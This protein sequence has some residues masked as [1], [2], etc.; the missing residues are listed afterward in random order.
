M[1]YIYSIV[2]GLC[3]LAI[4]VM[5]QRFYIDLTPVEPEE[6]TLGRATGTY[7]RNLLPEVTSAYD[8]GTS[9]LKWNRLFNNYTSSTITET[10]IIDLPLAAAPAYQPGRLFYE[11]YGAL[12]GLSFYSSEADSI[13][14]IGK[15]NWKDVRNCNSGSVIA[16]GTAVYL[17]GV[18]VGQIPCVLPANATVLNNADL[19]VGLT[20]HSI[21]NNTNGVVTTF[22][23]LNGLNTSSFTDGDKV[24][25]A[26]STDGALNNMTN[27]TSTKPNSPFATVNLGEVDYSHVT[28]GKLEV[29]IQHPALLN[30]LYEMYVQSPTA[31]QVMAYNATDSYWTNTSSLSIDNLT[32]STMD[33]VA[34]ATYRT[35]NDW[36]KL[37]NSAG[38][39][40]GGTITDIGG[41]AVSVSAGTGLV[42]VADDDVSDVKFIDWVASSTIDIP[43]NTTRYIGVEYNAGS[44]RVTLR[45]TENF[46]LDTNFQL[47]KVVNENGTLHIL[48]NPW[49]VGDGLTNVIERFQ[50]EGTLVRDDRVGGLQI[51]VPGTRNVAVTAGT[52]WSRLNEFLIP[53]LDTSISGT[54]E[55]YWYN[56]VAGTWSKINDASYPVLYYNN[57]A[58]AA[59]TTMTNNWY[60][61]WWVYAEAD[62][63]EIA[64]IYPQ[65]QYSTSAQ[66][67]AEAPPTLIPTH[68]REDSI[69]LGRILFRQNVNT[70]V[71][72][73]SAFAT[74]FQASLAADHANLSNLDYASAGHTGFAGTNQSLAQPITYVSSTAISSSY[75]NAT[76]VSTTNLIAS[77]TTFSGETTAGTTYANPV[78]NFPTNGT[79]QTYLMTLG[80]KTA[81]TWHLGIGFYTGIL[82]PTITSRAGGLMLA[83]NNTG[84]SLFP[85]S[86]NANDIGTNGNYWRSMYYGTTL[87]AKTASGVNA[88]SLLTNGARV[89]FGAGASDYASS[90]GTIVNFAGDLGT[91]STAWMTSE[92]ICPNSTNPTIDK[93]GELAI[94]TTT[95]SLRFHD[96]TAER[97]LYPD[98]PTCI[99][100]TSSTAQAISGMDATSTLEIGTMFRPET[101]TYGY[102]YAKNGTGGVD[103]IDGA[104]NATDYMPCTTLTT[105]TRNT[106]TTNNTFVMGE[107]FSIRARVNTGAE[108]LS[109]CVLRRQD[110]D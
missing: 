49:W 72:V 44:P 98:K 18:V 9:T 60:A 103:F 48:N 39:L 17:T 45:T 89:D 43:A 99:P 15:E 34:G 36:F 6:Q 52:L 85:L 110:A 87:N 77:T 105:S 41:A 93:A 31:D 30:D 50:S 80:G 38:R 53:A 94:E 61:N 70:P 27:L 56:G 47:G 28:L 25:L 33:G 82:A 24:Y 23:V 5:A 3:L 95:S 68:I 79:N 66:A 106:F 76:T 108:Q 8:L 59:T 11:Q 58:L 65:N 83:L 14:N 81:S 46:D 42:R 92:L 109:I 71:E 20:T 74:T 86:P 104:G 1:K 67:E 62:T 35:V 37:L 51:S 16:D 100:F 102:C 55:Q 4:P 32:L 91:S 22:G 57:T 88:L 96:G 101:W 12:D 73:Q 75:L 107:A 40:T 64:L 78:V 90:N 10:N 84:D 54:V 63:G 29:D 2:V 7:N 97:S 13:L 26:T 21:E 69:L 19:V